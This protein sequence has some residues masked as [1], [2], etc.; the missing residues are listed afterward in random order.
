M[1]FSEAIIGENTAIEI[2]VFREAAYHDGSS[3]QSAVSLDQT[4]IRLIERHDFALRHDVSGS[5][6][7]TVKWI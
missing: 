1:D 7:T 6:I 3:V 4:V 2:D 5:V